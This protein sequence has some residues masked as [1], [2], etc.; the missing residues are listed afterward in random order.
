[1]AVRGVALAVPEQ[2]SGRVHGQHQPA[3]QGGVELLPSVEATLWRR[4]SA[5]DEPARGA[6][7]PAR[8]VAVEAVD[9]AR[10]PGQRAP[11]AEQREQGEPA[12]QGDGA[13]EMPGLCGG[14]VEDA[15]E[16]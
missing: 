6:L 8:V 3:D 4:R 5:A 13:P 10:A 15:L 2:E 12:D 7:E 14:P 9:L 1:K 11:V 16:R